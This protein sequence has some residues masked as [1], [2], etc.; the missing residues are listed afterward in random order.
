MKAKIQVDIIATT[1]SLEETKWIFIGKTTATNR[2]N[3]MQTRLPMDTV[4]EKTVRKFFNLQKAS[5]AVPPIGH[6]QELD[7]DVFANSIGIA[8]SGK[9]KS[10]T[11][12]LTI[13]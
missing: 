12:M 11:A 4:T 1:R 3:A 6:C 10:E 8:V 13:K 5:P 2:S 9:T 7:A